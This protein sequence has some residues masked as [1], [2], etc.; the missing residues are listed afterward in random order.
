MAID[1]SI[2]CS[3]TNGVVEKMGK[4]LVRHV[5]NPP[6]I[7]H[8][9]LR[10][11]KLFC[12]ACNATCGE[13]SLSDSRLWCVNGSRH[14]W[15]FRTMRQPC[16]VDA[17]QLPSWQTAELHVSGP[18]MCPGWRDQRSEVR[19]RIASCFYLLNMHTC[20]VVSFC[21]RSRQKIICH[22]WHLLFYLLL[23]RRLPYCSCLTGSS[24]IRLSLSLFLFVVDS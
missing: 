2:I 9:H 1:L 16:R 8:L 3:D 19:K 20:A 5:E 21:I 13:T 23:L 22:R 14:I 4:A 17:F 6:T 24:G 15:C 18:C 7:P 12:R 11:S 10:H